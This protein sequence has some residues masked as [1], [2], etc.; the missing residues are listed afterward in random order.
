MD[1]ERERESHSRLG[2]KKSKKKVGLFFNGL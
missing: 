2:K 1:V